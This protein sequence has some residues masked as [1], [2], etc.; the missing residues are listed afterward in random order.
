MRPAY[1]LLVVRSCECPAAAGVA[2]QWLYVCSS[3]VRHGPPAVRSRLAGG[4]AA[5]RRLRRQCVDLTRDEARRTIGIGGADVVGFF[6]PMHTATRLALPVIARVRRANPGARSVAYGLYAPLNERA[7]SRGRRRSRARRRVRR[8]PACEAACP[9]TASRPTAAIPPRLHFLVPDRAT[10]CRR[11]RGTRRCSSGGERRIVGYTEASRGCK[12]LLPALPDRAGLRRPVPR[13]RSPR[14]CSRTCA[15]QVAAGA[16]T[17]RSAI[18]TSSTA[19]TTPMRIVDALHARIPAR[20][21]R[22]DDQGRASAAASRSA[23]AC[24]AR[25]AARS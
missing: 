18:P 15:A 16:G 22:R 5:R 9:A 17:S 1:T 24:C 8:R 19:P 10:A 14:S 4:L 11:S 3:D 2:T 12:H 21:L 7:A 23:A 25:P 13:R 6:L 20:H